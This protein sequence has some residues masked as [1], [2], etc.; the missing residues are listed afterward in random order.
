[1]CF[2]ELYLHKRHRTQGLLNF[3]EIRVRNNIRDYL[4]RLKNHVS[5]LL[6]AGKM[7]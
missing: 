4:H 3:I 1:M 6:R 2:S 7:E 5:Y